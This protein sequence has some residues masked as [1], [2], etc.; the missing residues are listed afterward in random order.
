MQ[1]LLQHQAAERPQVR[2]SRPDVPEE[3]AAIVRRMMAREPEERYTIPLLAASA[4][5]HFAAA[6]AASR[7]DS[8]TT[9][10]K[11]KPSTAIIDVSALRRRSKDP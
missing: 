2:E 10:V 3:L 9:L 6:A 7:S 8:L 11:R 5:R 4:L 1:K